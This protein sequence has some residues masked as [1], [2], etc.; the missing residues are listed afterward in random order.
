[1]LAGIATI[2]VAV[3]VYGVISYSVACRTHE[4][5]IRLALGAQA[6]DVAALILGEG[7]TL[8]F[9]GVVI[10]LA[11]AISVTHVLS[12]L[13]YGVSATDAATFL[14]VALLLIIVA[15]LASYIPARRAMS[16]DPLAA[17]RS[18]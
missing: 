11:G 12:A 17:L 16:V 13:L 5:G 1:M 2:L 10:G 7:L 14:G 18:E 15:L 6:Y 8:A 9:A 4:V 3:G